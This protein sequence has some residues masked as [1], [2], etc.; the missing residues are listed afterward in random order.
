[1]NKKY[2]RTFF[3]VHS[4]E[5]CIFLILC[6][7]LYFYVFSSKVFSSESHY[8]NNLKFSK[9][10]AWLKSTV[11]PKSQSS[12]P[13]L[14][15][16]SLAPITIDHN[17][18][19]LHGIGLAQLLA[20]QGGPGARRDVGGGAQGG[21]NIFDRSHFNMKIFALPHRIITLADVW[22]RVAKICH[23][24]SKSQARMDNEFFAAHAM[25]QIIK[26]NIS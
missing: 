26:L 5:H 24:N 19:K 8:I 20:R 25:L 7:L 17:A 9:F 15:S 23:R 18:E 3:F 14:L 22:V 16:D 6:N 2:S 11:R 10:I 12:R 1:M 21:P 13:H 4:I